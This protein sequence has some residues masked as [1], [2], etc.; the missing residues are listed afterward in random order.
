MF[1][2]NLGFICTFIKNLTI[3]KSY[4]DFREMHYSFRKSIDQ[5]INLTT[6]LD[7]R[8]FAS[9][10]LITALVLIFKNLELNFQLYIQI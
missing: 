8:N 10:E 5:V 2:V 7:F 1:H 6:K 3:C 9:I 4:F